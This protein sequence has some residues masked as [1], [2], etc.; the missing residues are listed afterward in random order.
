VAAFCE[1]A[2]RHQI[3][4]AQMALAWLQSRWYVASTIIGATNLQQLN[5]NIA[6]ANIKLSDDLLAEIEAIHRLS[7]SPA[8]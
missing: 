3:S 5:E 7:P 8:Q 4:P 2:A 1:L 6:S